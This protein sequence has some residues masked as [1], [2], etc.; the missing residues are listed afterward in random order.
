M[1]GPS[2]CEKLVSSARAQGIE[3]YVVG[4]IIQREG[5]I[6]LLRRRDDDF[7]GGFWELPG[8]KV[9]PG[10]TLEEA[11]V[12]EVKEET[13]LEVSRVDEYVGDFDY[14]SDSG[15]KSRQFNFT[16]GVS[17]HEPVEMTEHDAYAWTPITGEL[18]VSEEV[19][20][21]LRKYRELR[22]A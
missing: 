8:G 13:G 2:A 15:R 11:L 7:M 14:L 16:V 9:E 1:S 20:G 10:E 19:K 21:V 5:S 3:D 4:A 12:R 18:L 17:S 22:T 6:L